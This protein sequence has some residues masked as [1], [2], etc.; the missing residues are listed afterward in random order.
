MSS[1]LLLAFVIACALAGCRRDR[2]SNHQSCQVMERSVNQV[3][4]GELEVAVS[5]RWTVAGKN[6]RTN[7]PMVL[8]RFDPKTSTVKSL[9]ERYKPGAAV[10][11]SI[12]PAHPTRIQLH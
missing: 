12:D 2:S 10:E 5:V 1:R 7:K 9:E 11:C 4:S 8:G 6:Y 3:S